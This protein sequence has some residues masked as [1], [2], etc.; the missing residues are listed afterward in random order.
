VP[1]PLK[2]EGGRAPR[3]EVMVRRACIQNLSMLI[4]SNGGLQK[5]LQKRY[6]LIKS[7]ELFEMRAFYEK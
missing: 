6:S 2:G 3:G 4:K 5:W 1:C 7:L